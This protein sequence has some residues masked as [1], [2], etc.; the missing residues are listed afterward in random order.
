MLK[1]SSLLLILLGAVPA[2]G[3]DSATVEVWGHCPRLSTIELNWLNGVTG[4][5]GAASNVANPQSS[6]GPL[7]CYGFHD[8]KIDLNPG[9][10]PVT[11]MYSGRTTAVWKY[12]EPRRTVS[13]ATL[14]WSGSSHGVGVTCEGAITGA[15][16]SWTGTWNAK[17]STGIVWK[18]KRMSAIYKL[19][20]SLST[21]E[22]FVQ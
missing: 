3:Q 18:E 7:S 14:L 10:G 13:D 11:G 19:T 16:A 20:A 1:L 12:D 9:M 5:E 4:N 6:S 17:Q 8:W 21:F 2:V 22:S 15:G